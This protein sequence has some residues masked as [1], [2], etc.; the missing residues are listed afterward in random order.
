MKRISG[1]TFLGTKYAFYHPLT[2]NGSNNN[3]LNKKLHKRIN[4]CSF[5]S[6]RQVKSERERRRRGYNLSL[7][8]LLSCLGGLAHLIAIFC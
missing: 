5:E 2:D 3:Y 6:S 8:L 7:S 1:S 4:L